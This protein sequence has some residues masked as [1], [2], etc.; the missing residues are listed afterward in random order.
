MEESELISTSEASGVAAAI[1]AV[2]KLHEPKLVMVTDP[3]TET[4]VPLVFAPKGLGLHDVKA[5]LD[6]WLKRPRRLKGK[7]SA[8][9]LAS[10]CGLV[11]RHRTEA[12]AVFAVSGDRPSL[13]AVID[14]HEMNGVSGAG[15]TPSFAEHRIAYAFP[16]TP[17]FIAWKAA[18]GWLGQQAFAQFLD[19]RR[20][21]LVD[22][23]D[24]EVLEGGVVQEVMLK[25]TPRE[26]RIDAR[27][28]NIFAGPAAIMQLVE[29]LQATSRTKWS[30]ATTDR[31]GNVTVK[32]EKEK[33]VEG[34]EKIPTLFLVEIAAFVGG[35]KLTLPAR[36]RAQVGDDNKLKLSA[37]LVGIDRVLERGF[38]DALELVA[39]ETTCPVYRGTPEA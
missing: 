33:A 34:N 9:T 25:A 15:S 27:P 38:T 8:E 1:D 7:C 29:T 2:T 39:K 37:E 3:V 36:L 24:A 12:T 19:A 6:P 10:F 11:N 32:F 20:F 21:E 28:E 35:T 22:P 26:K 31:F 18:F 14:Y 4:A 23:L 13:V 17:E 30:E 5:E 16:F